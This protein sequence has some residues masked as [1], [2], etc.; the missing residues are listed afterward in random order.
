VNI[1]GLSDVHIACIFQ[2]ICIYFQAATL[3]IFQASIVKVSHV[4]I[5]FESIT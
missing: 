4:S 2:N 3:N 5:D 1:I